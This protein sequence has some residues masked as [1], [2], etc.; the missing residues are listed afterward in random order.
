MSG[1][2]KGI[3]HSISVQGNQV[4]RI[5]DRTISHV[6]S[7]TDYA[8][9]E[10][11][12]NAALIAEAFNVAD[13]TGRTPRQLA[14]ERAELLKTIEYIAAGMGNLSLEEMGDKGVHGIRDGKA[15]AIYLE[16][17]VGMAR[18]VLAKVKGQVQS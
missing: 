10:S 6:W 4:V 12:A 18:A 8:D 15:R 11:E 13:V 2:T 3:A 14:D 5:H 17:Y 9:G 16:Q 7:N 1:H